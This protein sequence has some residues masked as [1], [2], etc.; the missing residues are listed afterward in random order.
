MSCWDTPVLLCTVASRGDQ[1][2]RRS[3]RPHSGR[4]DGTLLR[5]PY[6]K[7]GLTTM[8]TLLKFAAPAEIDATDPELARQALI[9]MGFAAER[10]TVGP[11]RPIRDYFGAPSA[12]QAEVIVAR[13]RG[14]A[15]G[16][17]LH[18][19]IGLEAVNG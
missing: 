12:R 3:R 15:D 7:K 18:A 9:E 14:Y 5:R 17:S 4:P 1:E 13:G 10:I 16:E 2:T 6:S 19:D 11:P 8:S